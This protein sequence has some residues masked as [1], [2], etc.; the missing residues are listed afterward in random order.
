[1][2]NLSKAVMDMLEDVADV[3]Q[4]AQES[5]AQPPSPGTYGVLLNSIKITQREY[6]DSGE[7]ST[8]VQMGF[9]VLGSGE[10]ED[11]VFGH[12]WYINRSIP[13]E[14]FLAFA[15]VVAQRPVKDQIDAYTVLNDAAGDAMLEVKVSSR[16]ADERTF[17]DVV[18]MSYS[19]K[20]SE[21][22]SA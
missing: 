9:R 8:Y 2:G 1:M 3:A 5:G 17:W 12:R 14:Q 13:M 19:G 10:Y 18:A 7:K 20:L 4:E 16:K 6:K 15:S 22:E 11:Y 21:A